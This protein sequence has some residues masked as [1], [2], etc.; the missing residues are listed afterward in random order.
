LALGL[1]HTVAKLKVPFAALLKLPYTTPHSL[2]LAQIA[3]PGVYERKNSN[4]SQWL[5]SACGDL[6]EVMK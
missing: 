5:L 1:A 2:G 3:E 6:K 4:G